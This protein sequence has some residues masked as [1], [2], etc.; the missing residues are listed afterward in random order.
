[1]TNT[2]KKL[3]ARGCIHIR[4]DPESGRQKLVTLTEKGKAA[5]EEALGSVGPLL[6]ELLGDFDASQ[7]RQTLPLLQR[8]RQYLDERRFMDNDPA[9]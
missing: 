8:L 9:Q 7:L 2:L 3:E 1:M 4:P 6:G 5:R